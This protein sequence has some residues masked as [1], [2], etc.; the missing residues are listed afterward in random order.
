[1]L[2]VFTREFK[3]L[4]RNIKAIIAIALFAL[5]SAVLLVV[6]NLSLGYAG[7]EAVLS[8]MSLA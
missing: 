4:L 6:N 3:S 7:I 8:S 2:A 1:M 5:S